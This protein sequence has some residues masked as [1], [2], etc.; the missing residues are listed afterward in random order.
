MAGGEENTASLLAKFDF[1]KKDDGSL[2]H[3]E[4]GS[5][6]LGLRRLP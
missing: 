4:N 3:G 2:F 5:F 1:Y 6:M